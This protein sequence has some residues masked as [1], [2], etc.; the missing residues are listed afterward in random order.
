MSISSSVSANG[1]TVTITI[2]GRFD[3]SIHGGFRQAYEKSE[4]KSKNPNFVIDLSGADYMDSSALGMLLLLR[5]Y[6]GGDDAKVKI[7]NCRPVIKEILD[8]AN[9]DKLFS[10]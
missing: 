6:A 3:F 5:E 8:I 2:S 10:I 4:S 1:D 7:A 9:F